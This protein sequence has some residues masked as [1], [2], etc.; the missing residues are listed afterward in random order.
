MASPSIGARPREL[1]DQIDADLAAR[2]EPIMA[3]YEQLHWGEPA[4]NVIDIEDDLL[5]DMAQMGGLVGVWLEEDRGR[6]RGRLHDVTF[7]SDARLGIEF[8]HPVDRLHLVVPPDERAR[9]ERLFRYRGGEALAWTLGEIAQR[10]GGIQAAHAYPELPAY[11]LGEVS[12]ILYRTHKRGDGP[13][14]YIHEFSEDSGGPRP[15]LAVDSEGRP[16]LLGGSY[17]VPAEGITD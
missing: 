13:S 17:T 11:A 4:Q 8:G 16:W 14:T 15:W 9:L 2:A 1:L 12:H 6:D 10:V 5:P 3:W 7:P